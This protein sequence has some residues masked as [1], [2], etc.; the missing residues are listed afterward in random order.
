MIVAS[1]VEKWPYAANPKDSLDWTP[2]HCAASK[3]K[4]DE[5]VALIEAKADLTAKHMMGRAPLHVAAE[6][7]SIL[8]AQQ[9][10]NASAD[11]GLEDSTSST[12][13]R[14]NQSVPW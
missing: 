13:Y 8:V 14:T 4:V 7:D 10:L 3:N 2:L 1:P 6:H 5:A 11:V 9:L 12:V